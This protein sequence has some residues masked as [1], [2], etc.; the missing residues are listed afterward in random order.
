FGVTVD[1]PQSHKL[2]NAYSELPGAFLDTAN[3]YSLNNPTGP[4]HERG[5]SEQFIGE[6][7]MSSGKRSQVTL[8]TK[9]MNDMGDGYAGLSAKSIAYQIDQSL[10]RLQTDY[11]DLY[12]IHGFDDE[13][14]VE[15][16]LAALN[17]VI[18][19]GKARYI[20]C[21]NMNY[22]QIKKYQTLADS[23]GLKKFI[24]YQNSYNLI[25][26]H[27]LRN[28]YGVFLL[29]D[30]ESQELGI[31]LMAYR[32]LVNGF[33][34]GKY[35]QGHQYEMLSDSQKAVERNCF[36][37]N[38]WNLLNVLKEVAEKNNSSIMQT[39]LAAYR[40]DS[41]VGVS[42]VGF[43]KMEQIH[44]AIASL[45]IELSIEDLARIDEASAKLKLPVA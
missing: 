35:K 36:N 32:S 30:E 20:G 8:A 41:R 5:Q 1:Q 3:I 25:I 2:L 31:S 11:V 29:N 34:A 6:W 43:S 4:F 45:E 40:Q 14:P 12:Q 21:C 16:T 37:E 9:V 10:Q 7:L 38:G 17:D 24:S 22:E 18:K 28:Q 27:R 39:T 15:E 23:M 13:V 44:E 42:L 26:N 19:S 33:L